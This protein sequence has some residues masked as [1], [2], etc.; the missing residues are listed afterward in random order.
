MKWTILNSTHIISDQIGQLRECIKRIGSK[1]LGPSRDFYAAPSGKLYF[2]LEWLRPTEEITKDLEDL[3]NLF[4][5]TLKPIKK[6]Q[7]IEKRAEES[8]FKKTIVTDGD[9]M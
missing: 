4:G 3:A 9:S 6:T 7:D 8:P 5:Y 2:E 1:S